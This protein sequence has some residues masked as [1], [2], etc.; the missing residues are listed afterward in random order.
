STHIE[1]MNKILE[2][3]KETTDKIDINKF[4]RSFTGVR[5]RSST[6]DFIIEE[7]S[8][9]GFINVAGIQS[10]GLTSSPAIALMVKD[11][12]ENAGCV[13]K[14]KD[15]FIAYRKPI[16]IKKDLV[17]FKEIEDKIDIDSCPEKIFC[18][19][20]QVTEGEIVDSLHTGIKVTT[21]DGVKRRTRASMGWCQGTFCKSRIKEII[22]REYNIKIDDKED[23]EYSGVNRVGKSEILKQLG[24]QNNKDNNL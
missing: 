10:P 18:R 16:I 5:A 23:I 15:N 9:K 19:C 13:L 14:K 20:E 24:V 3:A 7:T 11:I 21:I 12:L 22:E 2:L 4:I 1:R 6:D 8:T 17:P